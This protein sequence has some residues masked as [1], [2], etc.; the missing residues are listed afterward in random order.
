MMR[1]SP[2]S[3]LAVSSGG[4]ERATEPATS[5]ISSS[6]AGPS[7]GGG[8]L[9]GGRSGASSRPSGCLVKSSRQYATRP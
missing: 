5:R 9:A 7:S 4:A 2:P 1:P 8:I 6:L 3:S